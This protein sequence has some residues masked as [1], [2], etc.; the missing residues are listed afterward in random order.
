[1]ISTAF[2][3]ETKS[4]IHI[5]ATDK[6]IHKTFFCPLG[7][8]LMAKKGAQMVHHY[9]H[10]PNT[11]C[12][13]YQ[14]HNNKTEW[15]KRWQ[16]LFTHTEIDFH[17]EKGTKRADILTHNEIP[18]KTVI[19]IQY[20]P[21]TSPEIKRREEIYPGL[22]WIFHV[23]YENGETEF[24][25]SFKNLMTNFSEEK[26]DFCIIKIKNKWLK[27]GKTV[28]YDC[29]KY[30]LYKRYCIGEYIICKIVSYED[31]L[32]E[33]NG[34]VDQLSI[35]LTNPFFDFSFHLHMPLRYK[36]GNI[37]FT[38]PIGKFKEN[39]EDYYPF[40]QSRTIFNS[41]QIL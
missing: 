38:F 31:F 1:M 32:S 19:E 39:L 40:L 11:T 30:L 20:S 37:Y 14:T 24:I 6:S 2:C 8:Q 35:L 3:A 33:Y 29:G 4:Y 27:S 22:I 41:Y 10:F 21:I 36:D 23:S 9:S 25:G 13:L 12:T 26:G 7:H 34:N 28:Y 15:H 16:S 18:K 17:D 5:S